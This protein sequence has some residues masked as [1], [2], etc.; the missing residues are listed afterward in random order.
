[1]E[2]QVNEQQLQ[3]NKK[4]VL[5]QVTP[6][7]KYLAMALFVT[8]PFLGGWVGYIYAPEK[9]VEVEKIVVKEV[10][11]EIVKDVSAE[12]PINETAS[13]S[14]S[15]MTFTDMN[16][17]YSFKFPSDWQ[18]DDNQKN[19]YIQLFNHKHSGEYQKGWGENQNKIEGGSIIEVS[20]LAVVFSDPDVDLS[21][22]TATNIAAKK[23][24][25]RKEGDGPE[26]P[27]LWTNLLIPLPTDN[28]KA[29]TFTVYG[30]TSSTDEVVETFL[31]D[32]TFL[33]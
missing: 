19:G 16:G 2:S 27:W 26:A 12:A 22:F 18:L 23:V 28:T 5:Y 17:L 20:D 30:D 6:F 29:V 25:V 3:V 15:L 21:D 9:V 24:Y 11:V 31:K 1:M 7:S 13:T 33:E 14:S 4:T 10:P 8:L 32:F